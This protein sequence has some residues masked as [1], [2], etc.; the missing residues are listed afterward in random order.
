MRANGWG[1][2]RAAS[3]WTDDLPS[4]KTRSLSQGGNQGSKQ[5]NDNQIDLSQENSDQGVPNALLSIVWGR[6]YS[7]KGTSPLASGE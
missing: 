6:F 5:E 3:A 4:V 1:D 7:W 2:H